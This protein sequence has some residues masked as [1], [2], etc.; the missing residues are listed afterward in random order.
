MPIPKITAAVKF[1]PKG[2]QVVILA[3][4]VVLG[5]TLVYSFHFY[6]TNVPIVLPISVSF[7]LLAT[8]VILWLLSHHHVDRKRQQPTELSI[9]EEN[10]SSKISIPPGE[11]S[12]ND[13]LKLFDRAISS[14]MHRKPLPNPNGFVDQSGNPVPSSQENARRKVEEINSEIRDLQDQLDITDQKFNSLEN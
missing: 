10:R 6:L 13:Y 5:I 4:V 14:T 11:L 12:S 1:V 9:W 8:I 2:S 7:V 3:L